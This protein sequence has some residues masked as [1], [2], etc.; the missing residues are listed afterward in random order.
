MQQI[1]N[2]IIRNRGFLL[3]LLLFSIAFGFTIQSHSYHKSKFINSAN[4]LSGGIYNS[5]NNVNEYIHL[6]TQNE[7]LQEENNQLRSVLYNRPDSLQN[8]FI[9]SSYS[10]I[11]YKFS[12]AIVIKNSYSLSNNMLLLNRGK[13]DSIQQ[14][15]GV[16]S[17]KGIVGII[18]NTSK[19]YATV[20]SILNTTSRISAQL[21]KS[22]HFGS[23]IWN[24]KSPHIVQLTEIQKIAPIKKGDTIVTSGRSAIFPKNIPVG[25]IES[26]NLDASENYYTIHVRLF[27]DMTSLEH[28]YVIENKDVEEINMLL[29]NPHE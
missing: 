27:N 16:I 9:D 10:G 13:R 17:S 7:L 2:F 5:V 3:Y 19:K 15:F 18:D 1:I 8:T 29:N 20:I 28:V 26:Y 4:F 25:T 12:P 14:D 11:S 6:R 23:L 21:K 22:N 24:G